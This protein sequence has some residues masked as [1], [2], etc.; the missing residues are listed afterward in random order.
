MPAASIAVP[1]V[2]NNRKICVALLSKRSKP[3]RCPDTWSRRVQ[4]GCRRAE[5]RKF[6]TRQSLCAPLRPQM[7][8]LNHGLFERAASIKVAVM[9]VARKTSQPSFPFNPASTSG[10]SQLKLADRH[11]FRLRRTPARASRAPARCAR[12]SRMMTS[13]IIRDILKILR[14]TTRLRPVPG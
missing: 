13:C 14:N 6:R 1:G 2:P 8:T 5:P 9:L 11:A 12:N 4:P 7:P 10:P 3:V